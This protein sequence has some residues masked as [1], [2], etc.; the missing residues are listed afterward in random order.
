MRSLVQLLS[1]ETIARADALLARAPKVRPVRRLVGA[2]RLELWAERWHRDVLAEV[3][4][5]SVQRRAE[6]V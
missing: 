6:V 1:D 5:R 2:I 4:V 3:Y